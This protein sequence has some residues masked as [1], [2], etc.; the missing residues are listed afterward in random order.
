M[1]C[2]DA[3]VA[4]KWVV[5][6]DWSDQARIL[7]QV[8]VQT[9]ELVIAPPV[10]PIEVTNILRKRMRAPNGISLGEASELLNDFLR[11]RF[12]ILDLAGLYHRALAIADAYNI[13]AAYDAH[14]LALSENLDCE[15]WTDDQRL[16]RQVRRGLPFARWIGE[17][18]E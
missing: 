14:Y 1:I 12:T 18:E 17:Y 10:M 15:F 16:W 4:A 5:N 9:N 2:V 11:F 3:S 7:Y 6:E 13:P 8:T